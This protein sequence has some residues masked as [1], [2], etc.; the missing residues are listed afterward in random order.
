MRKISAHYVVPVSRPPIKQGIIVFDDHGKILDILENT[1]SDVVRSLLKTHDN[2]DDDK[3]NQF[4]KQ[5]A[6][7]DG[8]KGIHIKDYLPELY[9]IIKF[10]H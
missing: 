1:G 3:F 4:K 9:D 2:T 8:L 6:Y 5:I 10:D 7:Q